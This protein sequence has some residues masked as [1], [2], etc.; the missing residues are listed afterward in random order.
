MISVLIGTLINLVLDPILI[1]SFNMGIEGA[2]WAT[3]IAQAASCLYTLWFLR[4]PA[5]ELKVTGLQKVVWKKKTVLDILGLGF[6]SFVMQ[7]TNSLVQIACNSMLLQYGGDLYIS[8]MTVINS[9]RQITDTPVHA[10]SEGTSPVIGYNYGS[11]NYPG[12]KKAIRYMVYAG[13]IYTA[14]VWLIIT[15]YPDWLISIFSSGEEFMEVARPAC[16]TYFAAFIF[17]TFQYAGQAVFKSLNKKAQAIFFSLL[18][19]VVIV[20]PLTYLLPAAGFGA[21]GVFVAE[22]VSNLLGG[23]AC[24]GTMLAVVYFRLPKGTAQKAEPNQI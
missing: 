5:A 15:V 18:R 1:F 9:I 13:M 21:M 19:K 22:P 7:A 10:L 8:V 3:V 20:V 24:F 11:G 4:T 23:L 6:A 12:V 2:A 14:A 17:Q 16:R